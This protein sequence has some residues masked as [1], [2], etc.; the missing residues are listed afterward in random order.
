MSAQEARHV[1]RPHFT[2]PYDGLFKIAP[3]CS[4]ARRG[5]RHPLERRP[6]LTPPSPSPTPSFSPSPSFVSVARRKNLYDHRRD[7][8]HSPPTGPSSWKTQTHRK[9]KAR[10]WPVGGAAR[11]SWWRDKPPFGRGEFGCLL[12]PWICFRN[13]LMEMSSGCL[14]YDG[15]LIRNCMRFYDRKK[16]FIIDYNR[17]NFFCK[18]DFN[19][20]VVGLNIF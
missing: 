9:R 19:S 6:S 8:R 17:F 1:R 16:S 7:R 3:G 14:A 2:H 15:S 20:D 10:G 11:V 12:L 5:T 13:Y 18:W 4:H